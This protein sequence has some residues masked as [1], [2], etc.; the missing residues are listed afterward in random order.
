MSDNLRR[1]V[2]EF[3]GTKI[4]DMT[5]T[6]QERFFTAIAERGAFN[7]LRHVGLNDEHARD[8]MQDL[9]DLMRGYRVVKKAA[10]KNTLSMIGKAIS[11]ALIILFLMFFTNSEHGKV[12]AKFLG[13]SP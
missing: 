11:W 9:R 8:D 10:V 7:A 2:D 5:P 1:V 6:Q 13:V 12:V 4:C 3:N